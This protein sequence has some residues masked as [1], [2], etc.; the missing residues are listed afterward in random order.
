MQ[1]PLPLF[2]AVKEVWPNWDSKTLIL[3]DLT[4]GRR[5]RYNVIRIFTE[6]GK[7]ICIGRELDLKHS[8]Q[9]AKQHPKDDNIP[10]KLKG[11]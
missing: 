11:Y 1:L 10:K 9:I 4:S 6:T 8:R 3:P 7:T 5:N 2:N